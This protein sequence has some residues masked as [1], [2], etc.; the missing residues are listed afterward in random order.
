[1]K[2]QIESL[3]SKAMSKIECNKRV[4]K[5]YLQGFS[6]DD[7]F[8]ES[9]FRSSVFRILNLANVDLNRGRIKGSLGPRRKN[10]NSEE[11]L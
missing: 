5:M 11:N 8:K 1:M 7:I 3:S 10:V 2:K 6:I 9:G 4:V